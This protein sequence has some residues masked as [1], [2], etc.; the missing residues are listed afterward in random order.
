MARPGSRSHSGCGRAGGTSLL[1][2]EALFSQ[3]FMIGVPLGTVKEKKAAVICPSP[4]F[5]VTS[6][7]TLSFRGLPG[8]SSSRM[9]TRLTLLALGWPWTLAALPPGTAQLSAQL[10]SPRSIYQLE[11]DLH[12]VFSRRRMRA[13]FGRRS[14]PERFCLV[15]RVQFSDFFSTGERTAPLHGCC[16][17]PP[18]TEVS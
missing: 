15:P 13:W 14:S 16:S 6:R 7:A 18:I 2:P 17:R 11:A 12:G 8:V 4:I 5:V 1:D 9:R 10:E 3:R